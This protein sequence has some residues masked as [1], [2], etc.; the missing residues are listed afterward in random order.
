M[1]NALAAD[2]LVDFDDPEAIIARMLRPLRGHIVNRY[3]WMERRGGC[4]VTVED[5]IQVASLELVKLAT[6][7]TTKR[8]AEMLVDEGRVFWSYLQKIVKTTVLDCLN[9]NLDPQQVDLDEQGAYGSGHASDIDDEPRTSVRTPAVSFN[10]AMLSEEI[11]DYF[12]VMPRRHK[13]LI[14]LRYFEELTFDEIGVLNGMSKESVFKI[15]GPAV[16]SWRK[17]T[18]G[19]YAEKRWGVARITGSPWEAPAAVEEFVQARHGID[20]TE[21]LGFVTRCFR[22]DVSYLV[23]ALSV[24]RYFP[25]GAV[26]V[27]LSPAQRAQVDIMISAGHNPTD[28][29]RRLELPR[30]MVYNHTKRRRII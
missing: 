16:E 17:V 28:V 21:W 29:A 8:P 2:E 12:A 9:E 10:W 25:P 15:V 6:E 20:V 5:L 18:Q 23:D 7:W 26:A 30:N 22:A 27:G 19:I 1:T 11:V 24:G 4:L 13:V 3:A 14:A